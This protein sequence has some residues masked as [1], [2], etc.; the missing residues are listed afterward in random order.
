[1]NCIG[2][3]LEEKRVEPSVKNWAI[4]ARTFRWVAEAEDEG[5]GNSIYWY[6]RRPGYVLTLAFLTSKE[7]YY[8]QNANFVDLFCVRSVPGW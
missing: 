8:V 4:I 3:P 7:E 5:K 2:W 6:A 1:M